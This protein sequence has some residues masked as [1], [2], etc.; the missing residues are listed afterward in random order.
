MDC[1][2]RNCIERGEN[3]RKCEKYKA[4]ETARN[5]EYEQRFRDRSVERSN[6]E[7]YTINMHKHQKFKRGELR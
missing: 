6:M 7:R 3:C 5:A 4:Y 1:P 2:C